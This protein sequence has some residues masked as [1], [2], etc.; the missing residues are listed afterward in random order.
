MECTEAENTMW[1]VRRRIKVKFTLDYAAFM[2]LCL[3]YN[4]RPGAGRST[5]GL[6]FYFL[7]FYT[8]QQ[9]CTNAAHYSCV[10][11]AS[12]TDIK[13]IKKWLLLSGYVGFRRR[14]HRGSVK[15][16]LMSSPELK[17]HTHTFSTDKNICVCVR[18]VEGHWST[19]IIVK[20]RKVRVQIH[21][22][23]NIMKVY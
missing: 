13:N 3:L 22:K 20:V 4:N 5:H 12:N 9:I 6:F 21:G 11:P 10:R 18:W 23:T 7:F 19:R 17:P 16:R 8:T 14:K 2:P 15:L 1:C